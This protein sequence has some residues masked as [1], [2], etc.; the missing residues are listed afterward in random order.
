MEI[1]KKWA[2]P[3]QVTS[4]PGDRQNTR[5]H[6]KISFPCENEAVKH[7]L[8]KFKVQCLKVFCY[9]GNKS[10]I[11]LFNLKIPEQGMKMQFFFLNGLWRSLKN[12]HLPVKFIPPSRET[13]KIPDVTSKFLSHVKT[14]LLNMAWSNLRCS[15]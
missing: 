12:G 7:D 4:P 1:L 2:P 6:F 3:R 14:R 8:V 13:D 10:T 5:R 15:V 11:L 9:H